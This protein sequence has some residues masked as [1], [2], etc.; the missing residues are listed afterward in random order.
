MSRQIRH[1]DKE[2]ELMDAFRAFDTNRS[3]YISAQE[4]RNVMINMGQKM[5]EE[6]VDG[7]IREIDS[8]GDG[9]IN[10][11]GEL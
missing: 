5:T 2:G 4:L 11:E 3:G 10:F 6:E 7:M 1:S 8:N 9:K